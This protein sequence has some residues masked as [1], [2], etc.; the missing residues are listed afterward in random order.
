MSIAEFFWSFGLYH[1]LLSPSCQMYVDMS[2]SQAFLND[3]EF[4]NRGGTVELY[5]CLVGSV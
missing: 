4:G 3:G 2:S 1:I 5:T